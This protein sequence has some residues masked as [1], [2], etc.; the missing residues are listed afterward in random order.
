M[1]SYGSCLTFPTCLIWQGDLGEQ[2]VATLPEGARPENVRF[3]R[4]DATCIPPELVN[5]DAVLLAR[6]FLES[7]DHLF[8][9]RLVAFQT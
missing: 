1:P 7:S 9:T 5:F 8:P 6:G 3:R 4:A 2:R